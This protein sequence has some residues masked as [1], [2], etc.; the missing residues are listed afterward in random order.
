MSSLEEELKGAP[1]IYPWRLRD[2]NE[3]RVAN[4]ELPS[5]HRTRAEL[6]E[7]RVRTALAAAGPNATALD[8]ACN[9]GWFSHRLLEWGATRVVAVDIRQKN[10]QRATVMREHFG[11]S[12]DVLELRHADVFEMEPA[13]LGTFDVV[14]VLGLIYHVENPMG[15]L[16]LARACSKGLCVIESQLTRQTQPIVHG[17]GQ[18]GQLHE[19]EGSFAIQLERGDNTLASTGRVMSLIPNRTALAQMAGVA[20]FDVVEFAIPR[21][22]HNPQYVGGDRGLLFAS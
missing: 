8:L 15:V 21:S 20:G 12:S 2:G 17:L 5:I 19:S 10:L 16:R 9:E 3:V 18:T 7:P 1:W 11:I 14:L 22:D 6:I 4:A 13:E